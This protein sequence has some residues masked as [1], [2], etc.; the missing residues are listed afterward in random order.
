MPA[1]KRVT[2][3]KPNRS[4]NAQANQVMKRKKDDK[5]K[6][7]I[8]KTL[9]NFFLVCI[10]TC[11]VLTSFIFLVGYYRS[12]IVPKEIK[13]LKRV[14]LEGRYAVNDLLTLK[15]RLLDDD[16]Q[17]KYLFVFLFKST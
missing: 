2:I 8:F 1:K 5:P 4:N 13:G 11:T 7:T 10:F 15:K 3:K 6:S 12:P 14:E 16:E 9:C 17:T